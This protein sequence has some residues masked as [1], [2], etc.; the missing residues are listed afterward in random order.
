MAEQDL[1]QIAFPTLSERQIAEIARV[2]QCKTYQDGEVLSATGDR[3][4]NFH[5]LKTGRIEVLDESAGTSGG[6][7]NWLITRHQPGEFTGDTANLAGT[8]SHVTLVARGQTEVYEVCPETLRQ[9]VHDNST[10]SDVILQGF[11]ARWQILQQGDYTGLRVIGSRFSADT[12]RIREF[13]AKNRVLF[14]WVDLEGDPQVDALLKRFQVTEDETPVVCR[15]D[16]MILRNPSNQ[17]LATRIGIRR[18]A[19]GKVADLAVI[20]AGPAGL[21]AAVYGA[22]EGLDTLVL[23]DTGPGG[24]A[25][26]SSKIENYLGFPTG[27][28]GEDLA[29]R[30]TLQAQKFGARMVSPARVAGLSVENS[31]PDIQLDD[32]ERVQARC[33]LIAT[34]AE[35]RKLN[36]EGRE[37]FDGAGV[38]YAATATEAQMSKGAT[39]LVVGGGN[40]AGQASVFLSEHAARVLHLIRGDDLRKSM[41]SYLARRLEHIGNIELL[42][43][44]EIS[45]MSGAEHLSH[46]EIANSETGGTRTVEAAAVFTFIG[47]MPRT[48]WLNGEITCD[49]KGFIQTGT[50]A[51]A[52]AVS[53]VEAPGENASANGGWPLSRSPYLLETS[54]PG[55]FAAGDVRAGSIKRVASAVGEGAMAVQLAHEYLKPK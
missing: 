23:E 20:G 17:E 27:I 36:V 33:V 26:A 39:V 45:R 41:S 52:A 3:S 38:Y 30:A 35:Y 6:E 22:S 15:A 14:T 10:L 9:L 47:A 54:I 48:Q 8:P 53:Q 31:Y 32:G 40:S 49:R 13:L 7:P 24:Q 25:G 18:P 46:V 42:S 37:R 16:S 34:G 12:L 28:A 50:A 44:S 5:V 43:N 19:Q 55:V 4:F 21:A 51:T 29:S 1:R 11:I 2:A